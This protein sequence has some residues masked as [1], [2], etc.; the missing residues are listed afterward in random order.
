MP[1]AANT[2]CFWKSLSSRWGLLTWARLW[3]P[4]IAATPCC[5]SGVRWR[6]AIR[7]TTRCPVGPQAAAGFALLCELGQAGMTCGL[8]GEPIVERGL[9]A[10]QSGIDPHGPLQAVDEHFG[11]RI[12]S[13]RHGLEGEN[14]AGGGVQFESVGNHGPGGERAEDQP[15]QQRV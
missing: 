9:V 3:G 5:A 13:L 7:P 14:G 8:G 15:F 2:E 12:F 6:S 1:S 10:Q 11:Q 4:R